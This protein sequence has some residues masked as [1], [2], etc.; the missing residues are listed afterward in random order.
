MKDSHW[1]AAS[2][3]L[4][5]ALIVLVASWATAQ[6]T[7]AARPDGSVIVEANKSR[8]TLRVGRASGMETDKYILYD[9]WDVAQTGQ[10]W[11]LDDPHKSKGKWIRMEFGKE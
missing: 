9:T 4:M 10:I 8:Y 6:D 7:A 11:L 3:T 5:C 1:K 2:L